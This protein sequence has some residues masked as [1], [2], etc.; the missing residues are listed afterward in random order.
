MTDRPEPQVCPHCLDHYVIGD[1]HDP[2]PR[3]VRW[4]LHADIGAD[5]RLILFYYGER[6]PPREAT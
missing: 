6:R 1:L 3:P 5:G 2:C 4:R